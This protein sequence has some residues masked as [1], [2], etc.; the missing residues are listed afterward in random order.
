MLTSVKEKELIFSL[1][2]SKINHALNG[3]FSISGFFHFQFTVYILPFGKQGLFQA[4][5][6]L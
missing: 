3:R 5:L 2:K 6:K 1:V 4:T